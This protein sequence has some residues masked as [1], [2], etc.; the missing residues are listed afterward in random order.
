ML[1]FVLLR[2]SVEALIAF[3]KQDV[4]SL[5]QVKILDLPVWARFKA[6][7]TFG[8]FAQNDV[9]TRALVQRMS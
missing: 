3:Q 4:F 2:S 1:L 5:A 7:Q 6:L 9:L 8:T